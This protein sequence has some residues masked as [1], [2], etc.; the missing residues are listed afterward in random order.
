MWWLG[1]IIFYVFF[2]QIEEGVL[3]F[4]INLGSLQETFLLTNR[5]IADSEW[6]FVEVKRSALELTT[7]VDDVILHHTLKRTQLSLDVR[8]IIYVGGR[9][10][11]GESNIIAPYLG[12][13]QDIRID[14]NP[15]PT[16]GANDFSSVMFVGEEVSNNCALG[17]CLP[18]PCG[19]GN[20][21]EVTLTRG[22]SFECACEN[23]LVVIGN[24][25]P[26]E[27]TPPM[28]TLVVVFATVAGGLLICVTLV[29][30]G[31]Y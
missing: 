23:G 18:N 3:V 14:Q 21:S 5:T 22:S 31:E 13:L 29:S 26:G 17:L 8:P 28:F 19:S 7:A 30:M 10:N 9:P 2:L 25:C 20:C 1:F 15:L 16:S 11:S 4:G 12:C 24:G 6:H 27:P